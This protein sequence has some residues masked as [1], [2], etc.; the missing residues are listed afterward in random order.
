MDWRTT[1]IPS[2][3][4]LVGIDFETTGLFPERSRVVSVGVVVLH[5]DGFV[6]TFES[7]VQPGC[8]VPPRATRIHGITDEMLVDAPRWEHVHD[9]LSDLTRG[10]LVVAHRMPFEVSFWA[11]ENVRASLPVPE[12][13]GM[14]SKLLAGAAALSGSATGLRSSCSV[15]G[16]DIDAWF[17]A[18]GTVGSASRNA[19]GWHSALWDA[20]GSVLLAERLISPRGPLGG[21]GRAREMHDSLAV[22]GRRTLA[23][24]MSPGRRDTSLYRRAAEDSAAVRHD[25]AP[26]DGTR[27]DTFG[28]GSGGPERPFR[29]LW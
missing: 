16:V 8:S 21:P 12:R 3:G 13:A 17:D 23:R 25:G 9:T 26:S 7:L 20:A 5:V 6:E 1:E 28:L 22:G 18:V 4:R 24:Y 11:A 19:R 29:S 27:A 14:C 2:S 15:F 10:A